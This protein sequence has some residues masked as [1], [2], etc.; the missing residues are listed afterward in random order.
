MSNKIGPSNE[1]R[2]EGRKEEEE[3][4]DGREEEEED[5]KVSLKR[6]N[7][8]NGG[9][10]GATSDGGDSDEFSDVVVLG[11]STRKC[12]KPPTI[13]GISGVK[14]KGKYRFAPVVLIL[15]A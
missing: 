2:K 8:L 9:D 1:G 3:K 4:E 10:G 7:V 15:P 6:A 14:W 13:G 11:Q 12:P 5:E